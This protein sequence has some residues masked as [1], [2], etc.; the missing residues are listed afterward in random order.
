[1]FLP[2]SIIDRIIRKY[3]RVL[4]I[5]Y[6]LLLINYQRLNE[7]KEPGIDQDFQGWEHDTLNS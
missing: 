3:N 4:G 2:V 7:Y 1:M 6:H 5:L